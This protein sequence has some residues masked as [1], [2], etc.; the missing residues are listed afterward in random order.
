MA[1]TKLNFWDIK[2]DVI[3]YS[4]DPLDDKLEEEFQKLCEY[5]IA[6]CE[7]MK[8]VQVEKYIDVGR[9]PQSMECFR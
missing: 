2:W 3:C 1:P 5:L 4:W 7:F 9:R 6:I 8:P